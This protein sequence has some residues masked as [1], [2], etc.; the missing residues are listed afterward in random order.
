LVRQDATTP[1]MSD[2]IL[3][4]IEGFIKILAFGD[5]GRGPRESG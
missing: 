3:H 4:I 2:G 5:N 1:A